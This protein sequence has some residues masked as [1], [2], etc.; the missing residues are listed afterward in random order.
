MVFGGSVAEAISTFSTER[1]TL[2]TPCTIQ[3]CKRTLR[4]STAVFSLRFAGSRLSTF[5]SIDLSEQ[6]LSYLAIVEFETLTSFVVMIQLPPSCRSS[7]S[8]FHFLN[9]HCGSPM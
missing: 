8:S 1:K 5:H 3:M 7:T 4:G 6:A 9:M 2:V